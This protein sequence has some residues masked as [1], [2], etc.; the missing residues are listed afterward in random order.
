MEG[1]S[2]GDRIPNQPSRTG[3]ER[4]EQGRKRE[5]GENERRKSVRGRRRGAR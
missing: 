3:K 2:E 4:E 5:M 1:L